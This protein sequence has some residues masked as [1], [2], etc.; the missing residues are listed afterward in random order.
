MLCEYGCNQEAQFQL[1][2]K[3]WCCSI[4][5]NKCPEIRRKNSEN[6]KKAYKEDKGLSNHKTFSNEARLR[7]GSSNRGKNKN[8]CEHIMRKSKT[9]QKN[10]SDGKW[11][12]SFTG[13]KHKPETLE[14]IRN[15][16]LK[17][18]EDQCLNGLP[19]YPTI[20]KNEW[21][22]LDEIEKIINEK[23]ERQVRLRGYFL[24]G[25]LK[26]KKIAIEFDE[27]FHDKDVNIEND[28]K[29]QK[30]LEEKESLNFFRIKESDW[31]SNKQNIL[32]KFKYFYDQ[33]SI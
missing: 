25:F 31:I 23:I 24:D 16:A 3:K 10:Y 4:S 33:N 11:I 5:N 8:N 14:K 26:S 12:A 29:R 6:L 21:Q 30:Y 1:K 9:A 2:N 19:I 27:P 22:C 13:K 28:S 7:M 32:E 20:G 18:I 15:A 17:I